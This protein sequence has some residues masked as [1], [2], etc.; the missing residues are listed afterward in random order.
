[1]VLKVFHQL[2]PVVDELEVE[3]DLVMVSLMILNLQKVV[4]AVVEIHS[5]MDYLEIGQNLSVGVELMMAVQ[6]VVVYQKHA[7][8]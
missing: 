8:A 5:A 7:K 6:V 4:T 2:V 3:V 1:M